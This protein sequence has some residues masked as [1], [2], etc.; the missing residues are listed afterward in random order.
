MLA[1]PLSLQRFA[2]DSA[3]LGGEHAA[4]VTQPRFPRK[5]AGVGLT[6]ACNSA[7]TFK[8]GHY[9]ASRQHK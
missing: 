4:A 8:T 1:P 9:L 2:P 5:P 3:A 6:W 7:Q